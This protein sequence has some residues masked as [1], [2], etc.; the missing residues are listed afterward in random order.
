M[1]RENSPMKR[2]NKKRHRPEEAVA[3]LRHADEALAKG[4]PSAKVAGGVRGDAAGGSVETA[5][6]P[7][8]DPACARQADLGRH[9][10]RREQW[11]GALR[12]KAMRLHLRR[13]R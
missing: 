6:Q 4:T 8:P 5:P 10:R 11:Y 3:K 13:I 9:L 2:S 7:S 1:G 12:L